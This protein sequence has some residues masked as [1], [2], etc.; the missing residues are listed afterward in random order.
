MS[1]ALWRV[2]TVGARRMAF[3]RVVTESRQ[4]AAKKRDAQPPQLPRVSFLPHRLT[5]TR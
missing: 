4:V 2:T 5:R 1:F 3:V